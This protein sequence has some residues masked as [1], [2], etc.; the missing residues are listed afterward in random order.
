MLGAEAGRKGSEL[1]Y[2]GS[3]LGCSQTAP[4]TL[5]GVLKSAN[6]GNTPSCEQGVN[7]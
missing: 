5:Q 1:E 3:A 2:P 7:V 4:G 6:E